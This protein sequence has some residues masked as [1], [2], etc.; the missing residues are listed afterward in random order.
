MAIGNPGFLLTFF[1]FL[2]HAIGQDPQLHHRHFN[3]EDIDLFSRLRG[4]ISQS[5][6]ATKGL[7]VIGHSDVRRVRQAPKHLPAY[8]L[9]QENHELN[10]WLATACVWNRD[11]QASCYRHDG[12]AYIAEFVPDVPRY[13]SVKSDYMVKK[14]T[15]NKLSHVLLEPS[16]PQ[17]LIRTYESLMTAKTYPML[18]AISWLPRAY[19]RLVNK[20][21][22][23]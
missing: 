14:L 4:Y 15:L 6:V 13:L 10:K 22:R 17:R 20:W 23:M 1:L 12:D 5:T 2:L 11:I 8:A 3:G 21:L 18:R 19:A 9:K 16:S 7:S